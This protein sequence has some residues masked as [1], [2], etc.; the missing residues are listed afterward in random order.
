MG[1]LSGRNSPLYARKGFVGGITRPTVG[2]YR[3]PDLIDTRTVF[4]T[5]GEKVATGSGQWAFR[6]VMRAG[7]HESLDG[8][9]VTESLDCRLS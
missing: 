6:V 7:W 2:P 5:E 1:R 4:L 9:L 8:G 3:L